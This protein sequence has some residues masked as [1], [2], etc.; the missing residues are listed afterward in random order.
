MSTRRLADGPMGDSVMSEGQLWSTL[1][2]WD[3]SWHGVW[4]APSAILSWQDRFPHSSFFHGHVIQ[5]S[6]SICTILSLLSTH[7]LWPSSYCWFFGLRIGLNVLYSSL[8]GSL[9]LSRLISC[10]FSWSHSKF[11]YQVFETCDY[12]SIYG[13]MYTGNQ[14]HAR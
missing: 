4:G 11:L 1:S 6:F 3:R 7:C 9:V 2:D 12:W 5:P 14:E 13:G 8:S 10:I